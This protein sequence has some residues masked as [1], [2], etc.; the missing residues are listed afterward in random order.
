M[1][2]EI[3]LFQLINVS[4]SALYFGS[5]IF[6]YRSSNL[7]LPMSETLIHNKLRVVV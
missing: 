5:F 2:N 4:M 1:M 7:E 3:K 6:I